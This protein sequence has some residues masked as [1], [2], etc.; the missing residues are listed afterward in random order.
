[1]CTPDFHRTSTRLNYY[2]FKTITYQV[3]VSQQ[4]QSCICL[5]EAC[6]FTCT[7]HCNLLPKKAVLSKIANNL[8]VEL[9]AS[10]IVQIALLLHQIR[11]IH[12]YSTAVD[13]DRPFSI[14]EQAGSIS[15]IF[16]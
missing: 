16:L 2:H 6:V 13:L 15:F 9:T 5:R 11:L 10:Y 7:L 12:T 8:S 1:M 14:N 4:L 3:S